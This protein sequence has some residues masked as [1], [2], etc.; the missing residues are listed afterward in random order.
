ML[1]VEQINE[2]INLQQ[3]LKTKSQYTRSSQ[4]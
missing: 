2:Y 1:V 3:L 4:T